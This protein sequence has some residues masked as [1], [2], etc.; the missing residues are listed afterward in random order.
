MKASKRRFCELIRYCL[1]ESEVYDYTEK[2]TSRVS[3][4]LPLHSKYVNKND[5]QNDSTRGLQRS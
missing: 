3:V 2:V 4:V 1:C 5:K